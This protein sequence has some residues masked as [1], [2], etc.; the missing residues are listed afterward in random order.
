MAAGLLLVAACLARVARAQGPEIAPVTERDGQRWIGANDLA[1][2]LD[3]TKFW[4]PDVRKLVLRA[5][6]HRL[7]FTVDN[8]FA[9]IDDRTVWLR[10]PV[11]SVRGELQI[12]VRAI[13]DLPRDSTIA[14]LFYDPG[15][16]TVLRVPASGLVGTP[17]VIVETEGTR[18][19][20]DAD[21][22]DEVTVQSRSRAHFLVHFLGVLVGALP[23]SLPSASLVR[24]I[25]QAPAGTGTHLELEIVPEAGSFRVTR[26]PERRRVTL[27]FRRGAPP[28]FESF[29]PEG[30]PGPRRLRVVVIDPGHGGADAGVT[31]EGAVE[32]DLTLALAMRLK[33]EIPRRLGVRVVLT[34]ENDETLAMEERAQRANRVHADLVLSLHFDGAPSAL[35]R[36]VTAWCAPATYGSESRSEQESAATLDVLPWRDAATRY[37]VASRVLAERLLAAIDLRAP[38]PAR[39][40][41]VLPYPLLGVDAPGILLECATLTSSVDRARVTSEAGLGELAAAIV[42][43][44][45]AFQASP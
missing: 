32:K 33:A 24:A 15:R 22:S 25:R 11:A 12:P 29:A 27:V 26:E 1:R 44:I 39:L 6:D 30:P 16:R 40:R 37:A 14:R 4:R 43:G 36:G 35:A 7:Q 28:D 41:D 9:V 8:P 19:V 20:C 10:T 3:A 13:E 2:L 38:G 17:R 18:I 34:R 31:T 42:D 23:D 5:G 45:E 21:R